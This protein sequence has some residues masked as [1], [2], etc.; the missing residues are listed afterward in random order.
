[1]AEPGGS[2]I[3]RE[4]SHDPLVLGDP[5]RAASSL[6]GAGEAYDGALALRGPRGQAIETISPSAPSRLRTG[7]N[8]VTALC[9]HGP[10]HLRFASIRLRKSRSHP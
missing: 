9:V 6:G 5:E 7:I 3:R 10:N 2:L 4:R 1:M 8:T